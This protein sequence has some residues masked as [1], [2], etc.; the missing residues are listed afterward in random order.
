MQYSV[1]NFLLWAIVMLKSEFWWITRVIS[2]TLTST[3]RPNT[4]GLERRVRWHGLG[5][6][7]EDDAAEDTLATHANDTTNSARSIY[8]SLSRRLPLPFTDAGIRFRPLRS[9][10]WVLVGF[11]DQ[12]WLGNGK[13]NFGFSRIYYLTISLL[14]KIIYTKGGG[15][16]PTHNYATSC[17]NVND[18]SRFVVQLYARYGTMLTPL[19]CKPANYFHNALSILHLHAKHLVVSL[20]VLCPSSPRPEIVTQCYII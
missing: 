7:T 11:K 4:T 19:I 2:A 13:T 16:K 8:D 18:L 5:I 17:D 20:N 12:I 15:K 3:A 6:F 1:D 9:G 14:V 10:S